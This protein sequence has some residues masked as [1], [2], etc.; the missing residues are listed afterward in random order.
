[1]QHIKLYA[2]MMTVLLLTACSKNDDD[3]EDTLY[4]T[5]TMAADANNTI[6]TLNKLNEGIESAKAMDE[7]L[8]VSIVPYTAGNPMLKLNASV[9]PNKTERKT[10]V[11]VISVSGSRIEITVIQKGQPEKTPEGNTIEDTHDI[12]TDQPAYIPKAR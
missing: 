4:Q 10:K 3:V 1:M 7:W 2:F 11:I 9:N 8:T 5:V 12:E 6:V